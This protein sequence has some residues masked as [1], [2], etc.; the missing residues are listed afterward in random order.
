MTVHG[1]PLLFLPSADIQVIILYTLQCLE[2][3]LASDL[4]INACRFRPEKISGETKSANHLQEERA[5]KGPRWYEVGAARYRE[6]R[7]QGQTSLPVPEYFPNA[8]D[9][10][11]PSRDHGRT[12]PI[13][14]YRPDNGQPSQGV[15][16]HVH[17]GGFIIGSHRQLVDHLPAS[18][19]TLPYWS[20]NRQLTLL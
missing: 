17:G 20:G 14:V 13:R 10:A 9:G 12:V 11:I 7:E 8:S 3:P 6:M 15:L 1:L 16:L 2:M 18:L 19:E 5:A 4:S